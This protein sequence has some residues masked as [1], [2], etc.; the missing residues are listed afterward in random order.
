M[1]SSSVRFY[2]CSFSL[3]F[4]FFFNQRSLPPLFDDENRAKIFRLLSSCIGKLNPFPLSSNA[5][6]ARPHPL[7][8]SLAL[9]QPWAGLAFPPINPDAYLP[10][11]VVVSRSFSDIGGVRALLLLLSVARQQCPLF[12]LVLSPPSILPRRFCNFSKHEQD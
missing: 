3:V 4:F 6:S 11:V 10:V 2:S 1:W 12:F 7:Q 9:C 5:V 8:S